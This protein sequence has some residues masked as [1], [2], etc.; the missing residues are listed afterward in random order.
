M[1]GV[2]LAAGTYFLTFRL[3]GFVDSQPLVASTLDAGASI[4][5]APCVS[6]T[7]AL[8]VAGGNLDPYLPAS[9]FG[10][11]AGS[12]LRI[13]ITGDSASTPPAP[14]PEPATLML[15]GS[16]LLGAAVRMRSK[17]RQGRLAIKT[18]S[19]RSTGSLD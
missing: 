13:A 10:D 8:L 14:V 19:D 6:I 7:Q 1:Q 18:P 15:V 17:R 2:S 16:G 5:T 11:F 3:T 4:F 12:N 9:S